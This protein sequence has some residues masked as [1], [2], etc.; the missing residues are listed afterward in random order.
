MEEVVTDAVALHRFLYRENRVPHY[1]RL[2]QRHDGKRQWWKVG[3]SRW[4][5]LAQLLVASYLIQALDYLRKGKW[6]W[7]LC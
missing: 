7:D 3:T 1:Q 6:L 5:C 4:L 2:F